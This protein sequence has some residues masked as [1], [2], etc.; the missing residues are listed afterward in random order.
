MHETTQGIP[1]YSYIYL[2]LAKIPCFPYYLLY[3]FSST[4]LENSFC[5]EVG[6]GKGGG[7]PNSVYTSV[8]AKMIT[9]KKKDHHN[10]KQN[11]GG[12]IFN[13]DILAIMYK[14]S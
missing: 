7:N 12:S 13:Y 2:K 4:K 8:K 14:F 11:E 6:W 10:I 3:L 5:Q 1:R 9:K